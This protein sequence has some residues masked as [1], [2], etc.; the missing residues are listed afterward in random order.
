MADIADILANWHA[1]R[2]KNEVAASLGVDRKT[3]RKYIAPALAAGIRPGGQPIPEAR[4]AAW[5]R[6]W[7][8]ELADTRLRRV[9][10]PAIGVHHEFIVGQLD[11]GVPI[12]TVHK[13]LRDER[14]LAV[15]YASLRRY[16]AA[17]P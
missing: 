16:V 5:V 3:I 4:W 8:P 1:G 17:A 9:T 12:A 7:F 10:W 13:R 15:S 2:S 11:A 14:G 6:E